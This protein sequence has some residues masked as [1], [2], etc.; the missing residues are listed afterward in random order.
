[1]NDDLTHYGTCA[2]WTT[3]S[4]A[5]CDCKGQP[6]WRVRKEPE[7]L[8]AWRIWRYTDDGV[9]EHVMRCSTWTGAM[10]LI[11]EFIGL[12]RQAFDALLRDQSSLWVQYRASLGDHDA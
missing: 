6:P 1:L 5:D 11:D 2:A 4:W 7:E 10:S 3:G 8:F 12:R 9:Y